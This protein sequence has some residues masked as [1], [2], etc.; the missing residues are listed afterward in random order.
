MDWSNVQKEKKTVQVCEIRGLS[1]LQYRI[2]SSRS[3]R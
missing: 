2:I 1:S 3:N